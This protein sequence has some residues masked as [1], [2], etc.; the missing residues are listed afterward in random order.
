MGVSEIP[1]CANICTTSLYSGVTGTVSAVNAELTNN[2]GLVNKDS[3]QG[4]WMIKVKVTDPSQVTK[5]LSEEQ[6]L[7]KTGH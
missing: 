4:G 6:Y 1:D 5:L 2:P 3:Y 7:Q